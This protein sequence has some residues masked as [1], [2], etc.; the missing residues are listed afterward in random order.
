[1]L[2]KRWF[3]GSIL[4][5][6]VFGDNLCFDQFCFN[7][8]PQTIDFT[9]LAECARGLQLLGVK[10]LTHIDYFDSKLCTLQLSDAHGFNNKSVTLKVMLY[11]RHIIDFK[12]SLSRY[13]GN[14]VNWIDVLN[15]KDL[16]HPL[17]CDPMRR[18]DVNE[19]L[20]RYVKFTAL[21]SFKRGSA[22]YYFRVY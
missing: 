11:S 16:P 8:R 3:V 17:P 6:C 1:M 14:L 13:Y 12:V 5:S 15:V 22:M 18:Y 20:A 19:T 4:V 9:L 7:L 10:K 21:K 2:L